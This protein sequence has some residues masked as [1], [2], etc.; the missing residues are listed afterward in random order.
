MDFMLIVR[1]ALQSPDAL[2]IFFFRLITSTVWTTILQ[3]KHSRCWKYKEVAQIAS[4]SPLIWIFIKN[5][6]I[7]L[8]VLPPPTAPSYLQC[9]NYFRH[10][11]H[12]GAVLL[13]HCRVNWSKWGKPPA[14]IVTMSQKWTIFSI[15][16]ILKLDL[17]E[18]KKTSGKHCKPPGYKFHPLIF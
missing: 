5:L 6:D 11:K 13:S 9:S 12:I 15:S 3:S 2:L 8:I 7:R 4:L 17:G 16:T 18:P 14:A 10:C 1:I